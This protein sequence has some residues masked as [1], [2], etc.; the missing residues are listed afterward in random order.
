IFKTSNIKEAV[1]LKKETSKKKYYI[2][3]G[4]ELNSLQYKNESFEVISVENL[5]FDTVI[6]TDESVEIGSAA[7]IQSLI[8]SKKCPELIKSAAKQITNKNIRNIGTI[9]GNI[10]SN[11]SSSNLIPA[12]LCLD[13]QLYMADKSGQSLISI[14]DYISKE[15]NDLIIKIKICKENLKRKFALRNYTRSSADISIITA[16][17]SFMKKDVVENPIIAVGGVDK[18]IIRL[19]ELEKL[20]NG[21]K[22]PDK[23]EIENSVKKF[24]NPDTDL[25]GSAE[26]KKHLAAVFVADSL[27]NA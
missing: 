22:L 11:K 19:T 10:G 20:L 23:S 21:K 13:A 25:R 2:A 7:T 26:F 12:L 5:G 8:E 15:K 4:S 27:H 14:L 6:E 24:I 9:G 18:H 3:G 17:V 1:K 16:A